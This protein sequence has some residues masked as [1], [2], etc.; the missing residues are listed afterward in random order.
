MRDD[1]SDHPRRGRAGPSLAPGPAR[2]RRPRCPCSPGLLAL[3]GR[4]RTHLIVFAV[5]A[6][7]GHTRH[8]VISV[9][10]EYVT[11]KLDQEV[12][13]T[14][15]PTFRAL[16]RSPRLTTTHPATRCTDQLRAKAAAR[17]RSACRVAASVLTCRDFVSPYGS[18]RTSRCF[19]SGGPFVSYRQL[20]GKAHRAETVRC[21]TRE[22]IAH[23]R[24]TTRS[25]CSRD[26]RSTAKT[27]A[28]CS[29]SRAKT[30]S[31]RVSTSRHS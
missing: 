17:C 13:S 29:T 8:P 23:H 6:V 28:R 16:P 30:Q 22:P 9:V 11:T 26:W 10:G 4:D 20:Y 19:H 12:P 31:T 27:R 14:S 1:R 2:R 15:G 7:S 25:T 3:V 21:A 5:L 24:S 18:T